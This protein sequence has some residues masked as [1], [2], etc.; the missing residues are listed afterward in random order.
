[1]FGVGTPFWLLE[2]NQTE[3]TFS[4][5][6]FINLGFG[7]VFEKQ[8]SPCLNVLPLQGPRILRAH[9]QPKKNS[10]RRTKTHASPHGGGFSP[11]AESFGVS[12][13]IGSGVVRGGPEVRLH[14]GSARVP[15]GF[16]EGSTRAPG[17]SGAALRQG[18][19]RVPPRVPQGSAR[20][21]GWC[22]H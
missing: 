12:A 7:G 20:A 3:P 17:W 2:G 13:Q 14:Q 16:H 4:S 21:A 11:T 8:T 1:M 9:R 19:T 15:P 22:E 5:L 6:L 10:R 18:S